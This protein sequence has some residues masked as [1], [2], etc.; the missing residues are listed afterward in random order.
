M[1][2]ASHTDLFWEYGPCPLCGGRDEYE[3]FFRFSPS[4]KSIGLHQSLPLPGKVSIVRCTGCGLYYLFPRLREESVRHLYGS[5]NYFSGDEGGGYE[6]YQSQAPYLKGTF[7][8]FLKTLDARGLTGDSVADIGCGL[9]YLLAEASPFFRVRM[10]TELCREAAEA[11]C[12]GCD[13]VVCGGVAEMAATGNRFGLVVSVG[14]LEHVYEPVSF[15][16]DCS[17]LTA[18]EGAVVLVTPDMQGP[19]RRLLGKRWPSLKLPEHIAFYDRK[20]LA[21]LAAKTGM[22]LEEVF[23]FHQVFPLGLVLKRLGIRG[24]PNLRWG[25]IPIPMPN[26]MMAGVFKKIHS[27]PKKRSPQE[28]PDGR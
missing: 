15:L 12:A 8:R 14:V 3:P 24:I 7:R 10:G 22:V 2:R 18:E 28:R 4:V 17:R 26:V 23:P 13:G 25:K 20:T 11:A 21:A 9:G 6:D 19:W 27:G 1:R 16:R 5:E